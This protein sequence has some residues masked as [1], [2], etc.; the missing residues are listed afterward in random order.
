MEPRRSVAAVGCVFRDSF[1]VFSRS[2]ASFLAA[3]VAYYA[4]VSLLPLVAVGAVVAA[5]VAGRDLVAEILAETGAVFTPE[6]QSV[7]VEALTAGPE[8]AGLSVAAVI[9][10][11]WGALRV[12]RGLDTAFSRLYRTHERQT[13]VGS[14]RNG[15]VVLGAIGLGVVLMTG[16]GV[17]AARLPFIGALSGSAVL[18]GAL[19]V[20]LFPVYYVFPDRPVPPRAAIPGTLVAAVG[21]TLLWS[22]FQIY[23]ALAGNV[24]IYGPIGGV[25]LLV[26]FFYF[27]AIV[28][29][30]GGA[31]N[32][33]ISD[34][35][36]QHPR[37]QPP[38]HE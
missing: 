38:N 6:T 17:F 4:F 8:R 23:I 28:L 1:R 22:V 16:L 18:I 33:V 36:L 21:W 35:Q 10:T 15:L 9:L 25:L 14:I 3:A 5:V 31:A 7:L 29:L 32:V 30:L 11:L 26:T 37:E 20:V 27:A 34:R 12:F 19:A 13:T 24:S 2:Q